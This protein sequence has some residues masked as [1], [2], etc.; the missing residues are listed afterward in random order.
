[1]TNLVIRPDADR[2]SADAL[3]YIHK[4]RHDGLLI[5]DGVLGTWSS[6]GPLPR[7]P[8]TCFDG[9]QG[10]MQALTWA[11]EL[12]VARFLVFCRDALKAPPPP[13]QTASTFT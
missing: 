6:N 3:P 9:F 2:I 13:Q 4:D 11:A 8:G 1:M 12:R 5:R 10:T 7:D